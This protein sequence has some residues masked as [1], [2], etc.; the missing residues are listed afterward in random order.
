M[1]SEIP[2][3]NTEDR[4]GV[5]AEPPTEET[6]IESMFVVLMLIAVGIAALAI[7]LVMFVLFNY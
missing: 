3:G 6:G 4:Q 5:T 1:D 7:V 2:A